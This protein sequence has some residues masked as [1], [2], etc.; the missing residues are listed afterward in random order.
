[1][2]DAVKADSHDPGNR[3]GKVRVG[4]VQYELR[5]ISHF[6]DFAQQCWFFARA[7]ATYNTDILLFPELFTTQLLSCVTAQSAVESAIKLADMTPQYIDLF[8]GL[9]AG[10]NMNIIAGSQL[11]RQIDKLYNIAYLFHRDARFDRQY[12]LHMTPYER[13]AWGVDPGKGSRGI[14]YGLRQDR[15]SNR[16]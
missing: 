6:D 1:M 8:S 16:L 2:P 7:A 11:F 3:A 10:T 14:R 12:K 9:S 13:T 5:K 15:R 4:V